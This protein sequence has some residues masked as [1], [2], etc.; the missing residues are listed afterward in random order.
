[1]CCVELFK[2]GLVATGGMDAKVIFWDLHDCIRSVPG[3]EQPGG[4][5]GPDR[6]GYQKLT[7]VT[8]VLFCSTCRDAESHIPPG[9]PCVV[10]ICG[11]KYHRHGIRALAFSAEHEVL[12]SVGFDINAF[13]WDTNSYL[14][15]ARLI[16][17]RCSLVDVKIVKHETER[18]GLPAPLL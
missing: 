15:Q 7:C 2:V 12:V 18:C 16:G 14:M 5:I 8:Y 17:H 1:M 11:P 13:A 4:P 9:P 10:A 6:S 3:A